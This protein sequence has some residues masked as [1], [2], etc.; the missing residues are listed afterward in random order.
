[1]FAGISV[2][3]Q[4]DRWH[5]VVIERGDP[6]PAPLGEPRSQRP[7]AANAIA[8]FD[9]T[10]LRKEKMSQASLPSGVPAGVSDLDGFLIRFLVERTGYP[11]DVVELDADFEAD[12]GIDSSRKAQLL[13][14]LCENFQVNLSLTAFP[15][16]RHVKDF[17][18]KMGVA[19][20]CEP[21]Q[22]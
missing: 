8:H 1:L 3:T 18:V 9:A 19:A 16:L 2:Q 15:T 5:H 22:E 21:G 13:G 12:L 14:E 20:R 17:L 11:V 4:E 7:A 10:L 6:L